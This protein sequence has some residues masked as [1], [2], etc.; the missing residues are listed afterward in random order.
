M[1]ENVSVFNRG[2]VQENKTT[3]NSMTNPQ[4]QAYTEGQK[5]RFIPCE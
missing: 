1:I 2:Y 3:V 4:V 5:W